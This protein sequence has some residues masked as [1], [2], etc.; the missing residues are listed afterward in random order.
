MTTGLHVP[1]RTRKPLSTQTRISNILNLEVAN[2]FAFFSL[3]FAASEQ[4]K[5]TQ[6]IIVYAVREIYAHFKG[7]KIEGKIAGQG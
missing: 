2:A 1:V 5:C 7:A 4:R 3:L 6:S